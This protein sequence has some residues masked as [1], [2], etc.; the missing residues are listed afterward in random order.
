MGALSY[1]GLLAYWVVLY[2]RPADWVK[3]VLDWPIEMVVALATFGLGLIKGRSPRT[4]PIPAQTWFLGLWVVAVFLSDLVNGH[5]SE[6]MQQGSRYAKLAAVFVMFWLVID[7]TPKLRGVVLTMIVLSGLLGMQG[8][9][10]KAHGVGWAGQPMYWGD[11]I[12]WVGLWDG[13]NMLSLLLVTS[14]PFIL[15]TLTGPWRWL[16]KVIAATAGVFVLIG[17]Y[18]ANSRG[19]WMAL[20]VIILFNFRERFGWKGIALAGMVL[21][22]LFAFGP[23]RL[24]EMDLQEK[25]ARH[26]IDMWAEGLEMVKGHPVLGIGKGQFAVYT[27]SLI[28]HNTLIQ[29]AGETGM[30]GLFL[31]LGVLYLS[32]KSVLMVHKHRERLTPQLQSLNRALLAAFMGYLVGSFFV[33]ADLEI[34]YILCAFSAIVL[35]IAR[36]ET[37]DPLSVSCGFNDLT[38]IGGIAVG[39]VCLIYVLTATVSMLT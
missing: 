3:S 32:F 29:N 22:M 9:Y 39:G 19:G 10:Q 7:S 35:V 1:L 16:S 4:G 23:S 12:R 24:S 13:A 25:S 30:L 38:A 5:F 8:M 26:R 33:V 28:A 14:V 37:G 36:R 20:A 18:L 34:L 27:G 17:L 15:E 11:R 2:V 31:W 21:A 6:A